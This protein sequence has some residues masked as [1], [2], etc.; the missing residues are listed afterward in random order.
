MYKAGKIVDF[1]MAEHKGKSGDRFA[2]DNVETCESRLPLV[3]I[4]IW[5]INYSAIAVA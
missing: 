5:L 3:F 1:S 4:E 2:G